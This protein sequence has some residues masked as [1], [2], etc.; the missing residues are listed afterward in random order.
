MLAKAGKKQWFLTIKTLLCTNCTCV[1]THA[2]SSDFFVVA[3]RNFLTGRVILTSDHST[4]NFRTE[5]NPLIL[6]ETK[7]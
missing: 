6:Y 2:F 1:M 3:A 7:L 5:S 4:T